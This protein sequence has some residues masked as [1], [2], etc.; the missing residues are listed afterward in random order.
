MS[1]IGLKSAIQII[2]HGKRYPPLLRSRIFFLITD[3]LGGVN[4]SAYNCA[5]SCA[6]KFYPDNTDT[7]NTTAYETTYNCIANCTGTSFP[8]WAA[9]VNATETATSTTVF[10]VFTTTTTRSTSSISSATSTTST[11]ASTTS[12]LTTT[13][14]ATTPTKTSGGDNV[15]ASYGLLVAGILGVMAL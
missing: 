3:W 10:Q 11:S 15:G 4:S 2:F 9:M 13:S 6:Q 12:T 1:Y 7:T 5:R 8:S 14:S